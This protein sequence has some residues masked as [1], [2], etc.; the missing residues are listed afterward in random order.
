MKHLILLTT[1][2]L[3]GCAGPGTIQSL[4]PVCDALGDPIRYNPNNIHSKLHA[5]PDLVTVL[6][7]KNDVGVNLHCKGYQ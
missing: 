7:E 1:L 3:A 5:G 2:T 4:K 6:E